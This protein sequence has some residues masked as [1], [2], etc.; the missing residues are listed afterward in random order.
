MSYDNM[1]L[2]PIS[3]ASFCDVI[4]TY[5]SRAYYYL[6]VILLLSC[7]SGIIQ[8]GLCIQQSELSVA[9]GNSFD[10]SKNQGTLNRDVITHVHQKE[11]LSTVFSAK[12][13]SMWMNFL[14]CMNRRQKHNPRSIQSYLC[15]EFPCAF[16]TD[17]IILILNM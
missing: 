4:W 17:S 5:T 10:D 12:T 3:F 8:I 2:P 15:S 1:E 14:V 13:I 16:F 6:A 11:I 7:N 9:S